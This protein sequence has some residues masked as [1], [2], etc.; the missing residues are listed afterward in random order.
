MWLADP[1]IPGRGTRGARQVVGRARAPAHAGLQL[2]DPDLGSARKRRFMPTLSSGK[3]MA[4]RETEVVAK[5]ASGVAALNAARLGSAC[6]QAI[7]SSATPSCRRSKHSGSVGAGTGWTPAPILVED[8]RGA[9]GRRRARLSEDSQPG[10]I[11]VRPRLGRGLGARGRRIL[12]Q[13]AGRRAVHAGA[14]SAVARASGRSSFLRRSRRST[15]Q[16]GISS[17]HITF[18]DEAGAAECERRGWLIR[19]GVQYHWLNRG[20]RE[21]RRVPGALTSRKRKSIRKERAAARRRV[22]VP[23]AC[24]G[25]TSARPNGTRCGRSTRTPAPEVGPA[26]PDPR[27]LRPA[28]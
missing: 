18:I 19:H 9:S 21:L 3:A 16:N 23:R 12:S 7:R 26:L 15:V 24:A 27:I 14:R 17:A 1:A 28:R 5:I 13:A 25:R 11:C 8:E 2:D 4:D 10:R 22:G 20:Y 6:R